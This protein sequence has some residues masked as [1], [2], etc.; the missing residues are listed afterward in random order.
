MHWQYFMC[1]AYLSFFSQQNLLRHAS[2]RQGLRILVPTISLADRAIADCIGFRPEM[3]MWEP[4]F[5]AA[6]FRFQ[7]RLLAPIGCI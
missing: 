3:A 5:A 1:S 6:S 2:L 7:A 4:L